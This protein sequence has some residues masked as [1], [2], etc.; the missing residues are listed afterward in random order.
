MILQ[1]YFRKLFQ[2]TVP[3]LRHTF[4]LVATSVGSTIPSKER[5]SHPVNKRGLDGRDT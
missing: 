4:L 3:S 5:H 2:L 1:G